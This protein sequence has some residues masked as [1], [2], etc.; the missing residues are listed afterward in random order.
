MNLKIIY[1]PYF[2]DDNLINLL[3]VIAEITSFVG[4]LFWGFMGDIYSSR[5][6]IPVIVAVVTVISIYL[7]FVR[8]KVA[9]FI[10]FA[11]LGFIDKG[12]FVLYGPTLIEIFGLNRAT[13]LLPSKGVAIFISLILAPV[14]SILLTHWISADTFLK[15]LAF[16]NVISVV[17]AVVFRLE[18]T[19]FQQME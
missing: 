7:A 9:V 10:G 8:E 11:F 6:M 5:K 2:N 15:V 16:M 14:L 19:P 13:E 18:V 4:T 12:I 3:L 17:L 1:L